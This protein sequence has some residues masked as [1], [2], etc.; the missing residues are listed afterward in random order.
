MHGVSR[1]IPRDRAVMGR[2][3]RRAAAGVSERADQH[4]LLRSALLHLL[5][6]TLI[7]A[8]YVVSAPRIISLGFPPGL[9]LLLGF[10]VVGMP[11][12]LGYLLHQ[13]KKRN[14]TISLRGIVL[15]REPMAIR[16]YVALFLLLLVVAFGLLFLLSPVTRMLAERLFWW[17]PG[18][19]LPD[20]ESLY[21]GPARTAVVVVLIMGLVVDGV[22]NPIVEE[23]YFRGYLLPRISRLRWLSPLANASLFTLAHF[24]QPYNYPLIF[25]IQLL[26]VSVVYWKRNI[27]IAMLAHCA[28]NTIGA[29][30]S[31]A[32][33][34]G[35]S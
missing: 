29:V 22:M 21:P 31:L 28:G 33:F 30:L 9:A 6:A 1:D 13:G 2:F 24:W 20:G 18:Y 7:L 26:V 12:Q 25:L 34:L 27:Y 17:L 16:Q 4:S 3:G 11:L 15:Y 23:L 35:S 10:L 14:G 8:F 32:S 19:M 5:P